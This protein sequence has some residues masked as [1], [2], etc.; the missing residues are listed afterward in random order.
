MTTKQPKLKKPTDV[1]LRSNPLIGGSRTEL[2]G[3]RLGAENRGHAGVVGLP[4]ADEEL[5]L[6]LRLARR[7]GARIDDPA[8]VGRDPVREA[9]LTRE[10]V[11]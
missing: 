10:R 5:K 4:G 9:T 8:H 2:S 1:D 6:E 7:P 3:G 11:H